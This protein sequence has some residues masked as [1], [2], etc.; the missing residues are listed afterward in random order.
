MKSLINFE[1]FNCFV[2]IVN[3]FD[4]VIFCFDWMNLCVCLV[5]DFCWFDWFVN[6]VVGDFDVM[7]FYVNDCVFIR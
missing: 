6:E 4:C 2:F 7:V 5:V 3:Y 1:L